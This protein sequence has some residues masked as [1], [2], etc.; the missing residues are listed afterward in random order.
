MASPVPGRSP[1]N[2]SPGSIQ[3]AEVLITQ[4]HKHKRRS[5]IKAQLYC[6]FR[7]CKPGFCVFK[8]EKLTIVTT[9][10]NLF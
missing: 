4:F 7:N 2:L 9:E 10:G 6:R 3:V 8:V 1:C 5:R